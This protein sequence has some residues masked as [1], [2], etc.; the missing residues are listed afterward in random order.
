MS[1]L[2]YRARTLW[3]E[4]D[5]ILAS[6]KLAPT[7]SKLLCLVIDEGKTVTGIMFEV[8]WHEMESM[9][10]KHTEPAKTISP[11]KCLVFPTIALFLSKWSRV[12][13]MMM[14]SPGGEEKVSISDMTPG[15]LECT[16]VGRG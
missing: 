8:H 7:S 4:V 2:S 16:P 5:V 13:M 6:L 1:P 11:S 3:Q 14:K 9:P 15:H 12:M 10:F